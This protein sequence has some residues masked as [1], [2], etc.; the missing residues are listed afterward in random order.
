MT[1]DS[2]STERVKT[3][4]STA[5]DEGK[6]V[7]SVAT[8]EAQN[9]ASTAAYEAK[10]VM[11]DAMGQVSSQLND[12]VTSQ[13]DNLVG[14]LR[15]LGDDL[16]RMATQ[17]GTSGL[18]ADLAREV[19]QR[20]RALGSQLDG[21]EPGQLLDDV[22]D[23]A[24]RR[25]GTFLLGALAAGVAAGRIF[26]AAA[27]GTAGAAVAAERQSTTAPV[28]TTSPPRPTVTPGY[29]AT[30]APTTTTTPT[31][32]T[33]T[34]GTTGPTTGTTGTTGLTGSGELP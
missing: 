24:R 21:R 6:H 31:G 33:G 32:T 25:P 2:G 7:G 8:S 19:S 16:E 3:A 9:V 30:P 23:F 1:T 12:Q 26:R 20:A 15:S 13:R 29:P 14:T 28:G 4:A 18:A 34:T 5:A 17:G 27:D 22:R 10:H 11:N